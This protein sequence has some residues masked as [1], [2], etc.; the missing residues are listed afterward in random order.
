MDKAHDRR[1]GQEY[2]AADFSQLHASVRRDIK[3]H[4]KCPYCEAAAHFRSASR[5]SLGRRGKVAH[6]YAR[7]HCD[8]CDITRDYSDPWERED[9]DRTVTQWE[10]RNVSLIVRIEALV[11]EAPEEGVETAGSEHD[12][13][14]LRPG[15]DRTR[16]SNTV[17]RGPQRLLEHLLHWPSFKTSSMTLRMPGP[18]RSEVAVHDAFV[19][20]EAANLEQHTVGCRGFWG[21]LR[22]WS[23]WPHGNTYFSNFGPYNR[24]FR[25][26]LHRERTAE[27]LARYGLSHIDELVGHY[28]LLFDHARES[29]SGRFIA[30]INSV[31]HIG[32]VRVAAAA[33]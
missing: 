16:T 23:Y 26:S 9:G 2:T 15:G 19:R 11:E 27:I 4:L 24:S 32:F 3:P 12:E 20:F 6:F 18:D 30:D 1:S 25:V 22:P 31:N 33:S 13:S 7:P 8:E 29:T 5:P 17:F 10:E 14:R 28:M 21:I